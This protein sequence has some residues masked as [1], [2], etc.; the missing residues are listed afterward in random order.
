[1]S[2]PHPNSAATERW[3][4]IVPSL[5][6]SPYLSRSVAALRRQ[7]GRVL[8][9]APR[10]VLSAETFQDNGDEGIETLETDGPLGFA[11]ANL[12]GLD[13]TKLTLPQF[14]FVALVNDDAVVEE[15]WAEAL[16]AELDAQPRCAAVQGVVLS[17][18]DET[19]DGAGLAWNDWYQAL[20]IGRGQP[21]GALPAGPQE[22]FGVSATAAI[23]RRDALGDVGPLFDA[24]LGSYYEDVD[25]A[26][27]LRAAGW[28]SRLVPSARARHAGSTTGRHLGAGY[29]VRRNRY[30]VLARALG[31]KLLPRLPKVVLLDLVD[32]LRALSRLDLAD[33]VSIATG[34]LAGLLR[35]PANL[36]RCGL[37]SPAELR[38]WEMP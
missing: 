9:V 31:W 29:L 26:L 16:L 30:V 5:G 17:M 19:V 11:A 7:G 36:G 22:I 4:A 23:Y 37:V 12:A 18:D 24:V 25:L 6:R 28:A 3:L 27:R 32:G 34:T 2:P 35:L 20:Q 38:R 1:M 13:Q 21:A 14:E 33:A 15:G 10:G 8:V